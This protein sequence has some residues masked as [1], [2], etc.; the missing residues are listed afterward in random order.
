MPRL[1][2]IKPCKTYKTP[3]QATIAVNKKFTTLESDNLRYFIHQHTDGRY[4][5]VFIGVEC[6]TYGVHFHF[7]V[8]G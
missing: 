1:I 6:M 5:P 8:I 2:E 7:N 3:L 4:F